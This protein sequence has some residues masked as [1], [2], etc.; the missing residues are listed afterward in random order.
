MKNLVIVESPTKAKTISRFLGKEYTIK[1]SYGHV[2]DLPKSKMG[3]D[4]EHNFE[5]QYVIPLKAKA[6]VTELKKL[7]AKADT[8]YFATDSDREGEAISWHLKELFGLKDKDVQRIVFH[9]IT[10]K[11]ILEALVHPAKLNIDLVNAQQ[12][13]RVLDRLVGYSLSPLLWSKVARGLSAGR[14]Q[15]VAV[16]LI[17][18]REEEIKA[19]KPQE[20]WT[21]DGLAEKD[22]IEFPVALSQI[23]GEKLKK[24]DL[25]ED[26]AKQAVKEITGKKLD[27]TSVT[28]KTLSKTPPPPFTTSTLQIDANRKL[29]FSAKQ[30]MM[31]AQQLY[32]GIAL[33]DAGETG[34]ITYMRT[35]SLNLAEEFIA[36]TQEYTESTFG[37]RYV[38]GGRRFKSKSK[39]AQ[40]AHEAIRP[41]DITATP[42]NVKQYLDARQFK[43]Y[44]LIWKRALASQLPAAEFEA[45]MAEFTPK[46]TTYILKATGSVVTF[47]GWQKIY[48]AGDEG[49]SRLP[50]LMQGDN[51]NL[52]TLD[53]LQHFT[54]PPA[55][56]SEASL[57][58]A[59]EERG[60]GR[61]STYAPTISTIIERGYVEKQE[62]KRLH[63]TTI[64]TLVNDLLVK[65][66]PQIVDY[67]F[68]ASVEEDLDRIAKGEKEWQPVI[69]LFYAPFKKMIDKKEKELDKKEIT[70]EKTDEVC[71]KCGKPMVIKIG[72]FG[73][74]LA[75]TGYPDCRNTKQ[76]NNKNEIEAPETTDEVCEKCGKPMVIKHGRFG[77][78]LG[79]SGYPDCKNIK[80]KAVSTGVKCPTCNIGDIVQKKSKRGRIFFSCNRYPDCTF[81]LWQKPTGEKCPNCGSLLTY[82][83][84]DIIKC[85]SKECG[86]SKKSENS[87]ENNLN[88]S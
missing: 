67:A 5:P 83:A 2:R 80:S 60:I 69:K 3:I 35:D 24:F 68:T 37:K 29:G 63:P 8:I 54:E 21:V 15:S 9:E 48:N 57:V 44:D 11:A 14:V 13:R 18:E 82:A 7:A 72:R 77:T 74:F 87:S 31:L 75:C 30:T 84:K 27:V 66:F 39:N 79:C 17:V 88:K 64:G 81:A 23:D 19:F 70:E 55:R 65:H 52:K 76:L 32:E 51:A 45:T 28:S 62:D 58:K 43:L 56:Y 50:K 46:G 41:T 73:K 78:F 16:R 25:T 10:K 22:G 6:H 34:L 1:S 71:E 36:S 49:D 38:T 61:P 85:S 53:S 33:G 59:L 47:D 42:D 12:A 20:Y 4:F 26:K 86:F 40:E